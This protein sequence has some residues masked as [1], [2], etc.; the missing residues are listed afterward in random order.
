MLQGLVSLLQNPQ[1][2]LEQTQMLL[3]GRQNPHQVLE[4][5]FMAECGVQ[6]EAE[7]KAASEENSAVSPVF[8]QPIPQPV[9]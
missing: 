6:V 7:T 3:D 4:S 8:T 1:A 5:L 9:I 2:L